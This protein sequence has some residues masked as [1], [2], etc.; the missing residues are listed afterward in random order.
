MLNG[1]DGDDLLKPGTGAGTV[2]G[3]ETGEV[4]GDTRELRRHR[5]RRAA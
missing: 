1:G 2:T 5:R 3:G 4:N